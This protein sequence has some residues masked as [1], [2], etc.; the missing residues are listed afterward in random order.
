VKKP[1]EC[2]IQIVRIAL[3]QRIRLCNMQNYEQI[4]ESR[5]FREKY[6]SLCFI[7]WQEKVTGNKRIY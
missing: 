7:D 6:S 1:L 5:P 2:G 3:K 4:F